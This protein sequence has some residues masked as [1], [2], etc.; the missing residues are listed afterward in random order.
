VAESPPHVVV[1]TT[2]VKTDYGEPVARS[3]KTPPSP[4]AP[5]VVDEPT[6]EDQGD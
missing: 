3:A 5:R 4:D 1:S 6:E 2:G